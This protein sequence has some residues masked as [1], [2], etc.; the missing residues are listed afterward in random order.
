MEVIPAIDLLGRG[1]VRLERG[2]YDRVTEF[3]RPTELAK[4]FAGEGARWIHVVDLDGA[5]A[6][7]IRPVVIEALVHASAPALVQASGG[8]RS[9]PDAEAIL[10]TGAARV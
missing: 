2:D 9:I 7:V 8:I 1:V 4:R 6:G 5:R 3:G 10:R